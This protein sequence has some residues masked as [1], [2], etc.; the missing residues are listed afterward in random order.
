MDVRKS[1]TAG[2][3]F[4]TPAP[5]STSRPSS[6]ISGDAWEDEDEERAEKADDFVSQMDENGIIGLEEALEE[7]CNLDAECNPELHVRDLNPE[8]A[9]PS[10]CEID[11]TPEEL[12]YNL[13]E[14][15]SYTESPGEDEKCEFFI[16]YHLNVF[17]FPFFVLKSLFPHLPMSSIDDDTADTSKEQVEEDE[18]LLQNDGYVDITEEVKGS[19]SITKKHEHSSTTGQPTT[20]LAGSCIKKSW[21]HFHSAHQPAPSNQH[22]PTYHS[23]PPLTDSDFPHLRH[24]TPEELATAPG[25]E[26]ETFPDMGLIEDLPELYSGCTSFRSEMEAELK[27]LQ[28]A[29]VFPQTSSGVSDGS[30]K[31]DKQP[32]PTPRKMR[33]PSPVAGCSKSS[34]DREHNTLRAGTIAVQLSESR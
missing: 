6:V 28:G 22:C 20:G 4:W 24:F 27:G 29:A 19:Y 25:I 21:T 23:T 33:Q 8:D 18:E 10:G 30:L 7:T 13:S 26:E 16:M 12:S 14:H 31:S 34:P 32:T 3:M 2:V 5:A 9:E 11:I 15:L 17:M 1:T